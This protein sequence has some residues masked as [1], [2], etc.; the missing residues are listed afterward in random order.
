MTNP[1]SINNILPRS[2]SWIVKEL[3]ELRRMIQQLATARVGN[4]MTVDGKPGI[5][6]VNGGGVT[7]FDGGSFTMAT[8]SGNIVVNAGQAVIPDG[9]GRTQQIFQVGRDD[10]TTAFYVA[11]FGTVSGHTHQE[12]WALLDRAQNVIVAEDTTS[13]HGLASPYISV[14]FVDISA[15]TMTTTSTTFQGLQWGFLF[16]QHPKF[17]AL[18]LAQTPSGTTGE[19]RFTIGGVQIGSTVSVPSN[20]FGALVFNPGT[21]PSFLWGS[22]VTVQLEGRVTGGAGALGWRCIAGWG[23]QS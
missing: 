14:P 21:V 7:V 6:I 13:G 17:T 22:G 16:E 20:T 15:P 18:V 3:K 8:P 4:R 11:D 12:A 9:T 10:G 5:S 23:V 19:F 1:G 2:E